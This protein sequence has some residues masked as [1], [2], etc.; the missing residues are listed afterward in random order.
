MSVVNNLTNYIELNTS[1]SVLNHFPCNKNTTC[2]MHALLARKVLRKR[3]VI[4]ATQMV[5]FLLF[6]FGIFFAILMYC[7]SFGRGQQNESNLEH[8]QITEQSDQD[9]SIDS[10]SLQSCSNCAVTDR[11]PT[12]NEACNAPP[13]YEYPFNRASMFEPPPVYPDTPKASER[14]SHPINQAF[15]ITNHI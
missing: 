6:V 10:R 9:D 1:T 15:L 11:P 7:K 14:V 2:G 3:T 4:T 13:L 5:I 8:D 12:Y